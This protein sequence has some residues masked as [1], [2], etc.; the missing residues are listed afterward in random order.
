MTGNQKILVRITFWYKLCF[1][2]MREI[3][4]MEGILI[5]S[6]KRSQGG[7]AI[8][9]LTVSLVG[10]LAIFCGFLLISDLSIKNVDNIIKT[11]GEAD[12][13]AVDP[14]TVN[15]GASIGHSIRSWSEGA[16]NYMYT[17]DDT[18]NP[19][20]VLDPAPF[21]GELQ[22]INFSLNSD[23]SM[24]YIHD[25]FAQSVGGL[26]FIFLTAAD[27]TSGDNSSSVLLDDLAQFLYVDTPSITLR[28]EIYI[29]W[30]SE[31]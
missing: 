3:C 18:S 31:N 9:E 10:I 12:S 14:T 16:D 15:T 2:H 22:N 6:E 25:N 5:M 29:P 23:L 8:V 17:A 7:Q 21:S 4:T 30:T 13:N 1:I 28:D 26:N 20:G 11:R 27:L 19:I 24:S